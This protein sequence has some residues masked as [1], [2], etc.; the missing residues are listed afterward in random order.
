MI[1]LTG[2]P[3]IDPF[4]RRLNRKKIREVQPG[5]YVGP[6]YFSKTGWAICNTGG[7]CTCE[8][9]KKPKCEPVLTP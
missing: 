3:E 1:P 6:C 2:D 9:A 7:G 8:P 4:I 5:Q